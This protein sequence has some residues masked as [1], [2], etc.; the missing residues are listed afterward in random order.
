MPD[1][2]MRQAGVWLRVSRDG[3][4]EVI[5]DGEE[6]EGTFTKETTM[7]ANDRNSTD[8]LRNLISNLSTA[9]KDSTTVVDT[10]TLV[11]LAGEVLS[12]RADPPAIRAE[13][14]SDLLYAAYNDA[15]NHMFRDDHTMTAAST[16]VGMVKTIG[17]QEFQVFVKVCRFDAE[18]LKRDPD[19]GGLLCKAT[20]P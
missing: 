16:A 19:S 11:E 18:L 20:K 4:L 12:S 13:V 10:S 5:G 1:I 9:P 14:S 7:N 17:G 3:W 2:V 8:N 6:W 15:F